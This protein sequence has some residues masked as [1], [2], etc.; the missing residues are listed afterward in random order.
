MCLLLYWKKIA[1]SYCA[2]NKIL[3][4]DIVVK[5]MM[6]LQVNI[7]LICNFR[8]KTQKLIK[9][10]LTS[11]KSINSVKIIQNHEFT[12]EFTRM[13]GTGFWM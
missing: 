9:S 7:Y 1:P 5:M 3:L 2:R 6:I 8:L 13:A 12:P 4:L 11:V 10:Y